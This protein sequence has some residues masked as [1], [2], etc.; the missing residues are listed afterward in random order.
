MTVVVVGIIVVDHPFCLPQIPF[1]SGSS[2][3]LVLVGSILSGTQV[4]QG[5]HTTQ[6]PTSVVA[7]GS[8]LHA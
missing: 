2:Q 3:Q 7:A 1:P 6:F 4:F 5:V 8:K